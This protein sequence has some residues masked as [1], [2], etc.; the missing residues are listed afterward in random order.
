MGVSLERFDQ[1]V[2]E[3]ALTPDDA[4][5]DEGTMRVIDYLLCC[6]HLSEIDFDSFTLQQAELALEH[7]GWFACAETEDEAE[8]NRDNMLTQINRIAHIRQIVDG[9]RPPKKSFF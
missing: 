3:T 6:S 9:V 2:T 5:L 8:I 7:V 1:M 4:K